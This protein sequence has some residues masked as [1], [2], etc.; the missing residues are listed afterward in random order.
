MNTDVP[1]SA[2]VTALGPVEEIE[3][4]GEGGQGRVWR[5]RQGGVDEV[6]K[7]I[8]EADPAR[9]ER[10]VESLQ[11][12]SSPFVMEY[13][14]ALTVTH[15]GSTWPAIRAEYIPGGTVADKLANGEAPSTPEALAC[16]RGVL[17]GLQSLHAV[18]RVHR[19]IKHLNVALRDGRWDRPVVLDLG[20]VRDLAA[21]S[22]T[23]YPNHLGTVPFMAPEQLRGERAVQR[24]DVFATGALLF[25][26]LTGE[27]PYISHSDDAGL[28][29]EGLRKAMLPRTESDEW[30]RWARYQSTIDP[31][32][33]DVLSRLVA[34]EAYQRPHVD[35]AIALLDDLLSARA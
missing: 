12:V 22:I 25:Y 3:Q 27:L 30:P 4:L 29:A 17:L 1:E 5:V 14:G 7:V 16:A 9:V 11:A 20:L 13:R 28:D 23:R 33:A 32:V 18:D 2:V 10:E 21:T 8:P 15:E 31:D 26:L 35:D 19:D 6:V 24:S 34:Q